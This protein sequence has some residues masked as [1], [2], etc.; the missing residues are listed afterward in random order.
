MLILSLAPNSPSPSPPFFPH[1]LISL[2]LSLSPFHFNQILSLPNQTQGPEPDL[3]LLL[4]SISQGTNFTSLSFLVNLP[5]P[6][7]FFLLILMLIYQSDLCFLIQCMKV[8][9][10]VTVQFVR[11]ICRVDLLCNA[12][13]YNTIHCRFYNSISI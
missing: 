1:S 5:F 12:M 6:F 11:S 7:F 3:N 8:S 13:Q 2:S 10:I 9:H 4:G